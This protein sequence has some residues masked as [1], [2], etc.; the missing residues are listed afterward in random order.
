M[1]F[2]ILLKRRTRVL[3]IIGKDVSPTQP[4]KRKYEIF[5]FT[6]NRHIPPLSFSFH[7]HFVELV[8]WVQVPGYPDALTFTQMPLEKAGICFRSP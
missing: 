1:H 2:L 8:S 3:E 5:S 6:C 7:I 4:L